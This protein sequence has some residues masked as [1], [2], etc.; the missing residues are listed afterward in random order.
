MTYFDFIVKKDR[1]F[2][3][4]VFDSDELPNC[5][6]IRTLWNYFESFKLFIQ[7]ALLPGNSYSAESDIEDISDNSIVNFVEEN[8]FGSFIPRNCKY[9][10]KECKLL[11][12][13]KKSN[14]HKLICF[15]YNKIM[16]FPENIYEIKFLLTKN[17]LNNVINLMV[18][19]VVIHD[20]HKSGEI[21]Y[22]HDF[23]NK[24]L[25]EN[26]RFIPVFTHNLFS[27]DFFFVVKGIRSPYGGQRL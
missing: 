11:K 13:K 23:C 20:S 3:R 4:N 9:A 5:K 17:F 6:D 7:I 26:Q 24:K 21:G 15:V 22:A 18:G 8:N 27:F 10:S 2:I 19:D 25:K 14:F 16:K 1:A 12:K